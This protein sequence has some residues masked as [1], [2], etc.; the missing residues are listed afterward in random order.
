MIFTKFDAQKLSEMTTHMPELRA[1][2]GSVSQELHDMHEGTKDWDT[3]TTNKYLI[4]QSRS[5]HL[6]DELSVLSDDI[7]AM[8]ALQ[9]E[10]VE[11]SGGTPLGRWMRRGSDGLEAEEIELFSGGDDLSLSRLGFR[12]VESFVL[13]DRQMAPLVSDVSGSG[14]EATIQTTVEPDVIEKLAFFG[15]VSKMAKTWPLPDGSPR[16]VSNF[17]DSS[18]IGTVH[19]AQGEA[20][21]ENSV[22]AFGKVQLSPRWCDSGYVDVDRGTIVSS[23][24]NLSALVENALLSRMGRAWN[25]HFTKTQSG[26]GPIGCV[27][28]AK[29]GVTTAATGVVTWEDTRQLIYGIDRDYRDA[30][31]EARYLY[32]PGGGTVGYMISDAMEMNLSVMTDRQGRPLMVDPVS[33][34]SLPRLNGWPIVVN[35]DMDDLATSGNVPMLFGDFSWYAN[36]VV[37]ML[38][39]FRFAD[40]GTLG[41]TNSIRF[42]AFSWR[43]GK[44]LDGAKTNAWCKL[45]IK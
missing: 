16:V 12:G 38:E 33:E 43:D 15:G 10:V 2:F 6:R 36:G 19:A 26:I 28:A 35:S 27:S 20:I 31:G 14:A 21:V 23:V 7:Q 13:R 11:T 17:D 18:K 44:P 41:K 1:L 8:R 32:R 45:E 9:P 22:G 40:S 42:L 3:D 29:S 25:L 30:Q 4:L 34:R 39:L 37:R 24:A 5:R